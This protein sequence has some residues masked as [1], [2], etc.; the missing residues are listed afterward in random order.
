M[1]SFFPPA[2]R[3]H[4]GLLLS[5][6][7]HLPLC[8]PQLVVHGSPAPDLAPFSDLLSSSTSSSTDVISLPAQTVKILV[9]GDSISQGQEGDFTWRYRLWEWFRANN[10]ELTRLQQA[11]SQSLNPESDVDPAALFSSAG[12]PTTARYLAPALQFVGP[13]NG[14]LPAA[15][16]PAGVDLQ[17]PQ[18][19]GAYHPAV[20]AAFSP[21]GGSAHFAVYGTPAWLDVDKVQA[22][23]AA[24]APDV[25]VLH[26]GFNDFGWW[27][28]TPRDLAESVRAL[29]WNARLGRRDVRILVADVSQRVRVDGRD[30]IPRKT[31]EYN[32]L[33]ADKVR[34]WTTPESPVVLV[35]VSEE[36]ACKS[37][38]FSA[39]LHG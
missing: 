16:G 17:H 25:V 21:G 1:Q 13:Y 3:L 35:R 27:G 23:V 7:S 11:Q 39:Q 14:T 31:D 38:L 5:V 15:V 6:L 19:W 37:S 10:E 8:T 34:E 20:D 4:A 2:A 32:A 24:H 30:D 33:L 36:Y 29:V 28:Q 12:D 22:R 9:C 18:S 26:V